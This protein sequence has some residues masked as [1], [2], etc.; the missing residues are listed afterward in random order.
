MYEYF[1]QKFRSVCSPKQELSLDE[2][3]ISQQGCLKFR[4]CDPRKITK[5]GVME[6]L[7]Y[8]AVSD[9]VCNMDIYTAEGKKLEDMTLLLLNRNIGH[10]HHSYQD[11]FYN[12]VRLVATLLDKCECLWH[13]EG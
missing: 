10:N 2:V 7:V 13:Y 12:S 1:L 8:E 11:K 5:Y 3:M 9:Y 4:T 6:R